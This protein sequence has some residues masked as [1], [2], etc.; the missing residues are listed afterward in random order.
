MD[1][2]IEKPRQVMLLTTRAETEI[3]GKKMIKDNVMAV[4]WHTPISHKPLLYGALIGKDRFSLR[5]IRQSRVFVVNFIAATMRDATLYVGSHSGN[6]LD[7]FKDANIAK[8]EAETID[9]CRL[10]DSTAWIECELQDE[11]ELGDHVLV[12]GKVTYQGVNKRARR[13]FY[14]GNNQF[15]TTQK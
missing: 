1:G 9:C 14:L 5:L 10:N 13:L 8:A 2:D 4:A 6:H 3:L 11:V 7:K 15:T 12:V